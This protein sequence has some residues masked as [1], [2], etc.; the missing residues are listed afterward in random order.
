MNYIFNLK[1]MENIWTIKNIFKINP[2]VYIFLVISIVTASYKIF[3]IISFLI[4]IHELG[5]FLIAILFGLETD[6]IYIYPLGGISKINIPLNTNFY[7]EF[8]ILIMGP[9]F[10]NIGYI[11]LIMIINDN[12]LV[13]R[14]H[15]GILLFN[16]L[17]IYPLDGGKLVNLIMNKIIP[18]KLSYR[19]I[20]YISYLFNII[21]LFCNKKI[22][23][24]MILIYMMLIIII[25]KEQNKEK[26]IYNKFLLERYL[27]HCHYKKNIIIKNENNFYKT[28]NNILY[29]GKN[30]YSEK[31]F[32]T[33]KFKKNQK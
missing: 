33:K 10:Q 30:Y 23:I 1:K 29:D 21:I 24:N 28:K 31:T 13:T 32:L 27:N 6:K 18:Y 19:I 4:T 26:F 15:L 20:I 3:I 8:I 16:L 11:L 22:S 9:I 12:I 7:K 5:H 14:I 17:P 25:R 2:L